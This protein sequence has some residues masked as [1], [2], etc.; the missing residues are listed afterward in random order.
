[1]PLVDLTVILRIGKG[2]GHSSKIEICFLLQGMISQLCINDNKTY[3]HFNLFLDA[4]PHILPFVPLPI[5]FET[6]IFLVCKAAYKMCFSHEFLKKIDLRPYAVQSSAL[7]KHLS[8]A[9]LT[10][11]GENIESID[12]S[13]C[14]S[15]TDEDILYLPD[16]SN[17]RSLNLNGCQKI[18]DKGL[19]SIS[20]KCR[21]LQR[22][23]I[24]WNTQVFCFLN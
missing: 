9:G 17:L 18:T 24:Y 3:R 10:N 12:L 11:R 20:Q 7:L 6:R 22:F 23:Q 4:L 8:K 5:L 1:M 21:N 15:L 16:N 13:F 14:V 2:N 19:L